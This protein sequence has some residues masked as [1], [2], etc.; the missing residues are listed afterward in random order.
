MLPLLD[1]VI[2]FSVRINIVEYHLA[3]APAT[4]L[5]KLDPR[6]VALL[7][8]YRAGSFAERVLGFNSTAKQRLPVAG[9][10]GLNQCGASRLSARGLQPSVTRRTTAERSIV[11]EQIWLFGEEARGTRVCPRTA[12]IPLPSEDETEPR[13]LGA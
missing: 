6:K 13:L 4:R 1:R 8:G 9:A 12:C 11:A 3:Q 10:V 5:L 2:Y 7:H